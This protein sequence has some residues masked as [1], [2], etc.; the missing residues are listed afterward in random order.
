MSEEQEKV[1]TFQLTANPNFTV[2][3][4]ESVK[5][6]TAKHEE[7]K[8]KAKKGF[9]SRLKELDPKI[10]AANTPLYYEAL[11]DVARDVQYYAE[12][13]IG[14][15]MQKFRLDLDTGSSDLW[16]ADITC[17]TRRRRFIK[18]N[19]T[20]FKPVVGKFQIS[21][22][23]GSAVKGFF[24]QDRVNVGGLVIEDQVIGL[25]TA[26]SMSFSNDVIDGILG[27]GFN[28]I[29]C[30]PGTLTPM[31]N[32]IKQ[33][34]I[35]SPIFSVWLGRSTEGGGGEY[36]FGSYD[37]ERI[38]GE[39]TWCPVTVKRYWQIKCDGLFFG[40]VDLQLASDVIVDTGTTLVI[41]PTDVAKAIHSQIPGSYYDDNNG[42]IVPNTPEVANLP[43]FQ[44]LLNGTKFDVIM[45]DLMRE[46]VEGREGFVFS[47]IA[48]SDRITTWILGDVFIKQ[49]YCIFDLGQERVGI[50]KCKH[51][52][53]PQASVLEQMKV[54]AVATPN[55]GK[56]AKCL[57]M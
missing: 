27:L 34:L 39:L 56:G 19:S 52:I 25:A 51:P 44:L 16:V 13:E 48:S 15:N 37:P 14:S 18:A 53:R 26:Q 10:S 12:V 31:D 17:K 41:V 11:T 6:A 8:P 38:D 1:L 49:N 7:P 32:M 43:G 30:M 36:R 33:N 55:K 23:D 54:D 9:L 45:K 46:D 57:I 2:R 50:A 29:S 5:H 40:D 21:Y 22:G 35:Q 24:G 20:T 3:T 4:P 47:G 28:S 42:W